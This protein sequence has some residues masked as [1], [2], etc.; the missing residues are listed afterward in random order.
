MDAHPNGSRLTENWA[1][2]GSLLGGARDQKPAHSNC[3]RAEMLMPWVNPARGGQGTEERQKTRG[4]FCSGAQILL[5]S[6]S[7]AQ[8]KHTF[9]AKHV[10]AHSALLGNEGMHFLHGKVSLRRRQP[11]HISS[12]SFPITPY[13]LSFPTLC[14][15]FSALPLPF[16]PVPPQQWA[17]NPC[18]CELTAFPLSF[19]S[20]RTKTVQIQTEL[21]PFPA[22]N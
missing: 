14:S 22:E 10:P 1:A 12:V 3:R 4:K 21:G 9:G 13:F 17:P 2:P 19:P 16:S 18:A 5:I 11:S 20:L 8:K 15:W 7:S 6:T